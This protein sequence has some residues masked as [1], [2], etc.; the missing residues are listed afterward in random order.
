MGIINKTK[1]NKIEAKIPSF[2]I[3]CVSRVFKRG[4]TPL[5]I[6]RAAGGNR[7]KRGVGIITSRRSPQPP[8]S[9][10]TPSSSSC[11]MRRAALG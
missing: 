9:L 11:S 1:N 2:K 8:S 7:L 5:Y 10:L 3:I 4:A 6:E